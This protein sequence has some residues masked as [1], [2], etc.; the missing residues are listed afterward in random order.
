ME[1]QARPTIVNQRLTSSEAARFLG[2][3]E[4]TLRVWRCVHRHAVP[5][6]KVGHKVQYE[7]RDLVTWLESRKV[8]AGE[9]Q[10]AAR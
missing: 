10:V 8:H 5:Y 9:L 2:V 1:I 7:E 6:I 4:G 3:T